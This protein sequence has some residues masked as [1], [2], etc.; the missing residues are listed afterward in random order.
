MNNS[1]LALVLL[2]VIF[3]GCEK[4][5]KNVNLF[6]QGYKNIVGEQTIIKSEQSN[7]SE[8]ESLEKV[9]DTDRNTKFLVINLRI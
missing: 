9:F 4:K 8:T 3:V 7:F 2:S 6:K 5:I 1:F